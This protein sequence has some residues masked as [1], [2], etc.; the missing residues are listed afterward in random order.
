MDT[1]LGLKEA[2]DILKANTEYTSRSS[3]SAYNEHTDEYEVI[4]LWRRLI[5]NGKGV[6]CGCFAIIYIFFG[7]IF[8]LKVLIWK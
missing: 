6:G 7:A 2:K 4:H 3:T 8:N 5:K 1:S